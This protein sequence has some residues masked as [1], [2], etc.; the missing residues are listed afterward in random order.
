M[1]KIKGKSKEKANQPGKKKK[2]KK[3]FASLF[4]KMCN[5][6]RHERRGRTGV[7]L[8]ERERERK[9][10]KSSRT[11]QAINHWIAGDTHTMRI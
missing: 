9:G 6:V 11:F 5:L 1:K 7:R 10:K 4:K 3:V 2:K 8:R